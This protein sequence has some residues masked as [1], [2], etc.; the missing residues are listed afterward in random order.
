MNN[1]R[2]VAQQ[3]LDEWHDD[4]GSV[5]MASLMIALRTAIEQAETAPV[6]EPVAWMWQHDE[7]GRTGFVD[8]WQVENGWQ[9]NN[10]RCKLVHPLY[11]RPQPADE[12][13]NAAIRLGEEL[14]SV[15]PNGYYDMTARQWLD[16]AISQQPRGK[17]SLPADDPVAMR[18][19]FDGY[20]Y[21]Y[22]D[23]GSGSNWQTRVKD[24]EPLYDRPRE[25]VGLTEDELL[26]AAQLA[27]RGNY[28]VAF[29][30][31]QQKLKEKND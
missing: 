4:P 30:R 20:G 10:P 16:W 17:N 31:I 21:R 24:A 28:L 22:I 6:Q 14:S 15:G 9:A 11:T 2:E 25:W 23:S 29:Q 18:W 5:R 19:D 26:E 27:E 12:W 13:K 7:T 8:P 1:L 3:A